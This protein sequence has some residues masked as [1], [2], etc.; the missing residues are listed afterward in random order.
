MRSQRFPDAV[1][2]GIVLFW[3][4]PGKLNNEM[5]GK[6]KLKGDSV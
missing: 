5:R 2:V 4:L 1:G 3:R 6:D